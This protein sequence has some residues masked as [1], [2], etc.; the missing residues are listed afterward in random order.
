MKKHFICLANSTK[1]QGRC[2]A[3]VEVSLDGACRYTIARNEDGTPKWIRPVSRDQQTHGALP[4]RETKNIVLFDIIEIENMK[5]C[6]QHAHSENVFY[7][8]LKRSGKRSFQDTNHLN[9][10]CNNVDSVF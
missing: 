6:H 5:A 8:S 3:G 4:E 2:L 1:Y 10:L 9:D 7:S